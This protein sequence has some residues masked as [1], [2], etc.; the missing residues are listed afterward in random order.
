M[1]K[2]IPKI[3]L[4]VLLSLAIYLISKSLLISL[5]ASGIVSVIIAV[6]AERKKEHGITLIQRLYLL[7][8][9]LTGSF[10]VI[11]SASYII[12]DY[13]QR[14]AEFF[15]MAFAELILIVIFVLLQIGYIVLHNI[16]KKQT[17]GN[18]GSRTNSLSVY[19]CF[20]VICIYKYAMCVM[21]FHPLQIA[22]DMYLNQPILYRI[23]LYLVFDILI[24]TVAAFIMYKIS[25]FFCRPDKSLFCGLMIPMV[26]IDSS[27]Y[28]ILYMLYFLC[29]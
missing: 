8:Y 16:D 20:A 21:L 25:S 19:I 5:T 17:K 15:D 27:F 4:V 3:I 1:K 24:G 7:T 12:F 6:V 23:S 18:E 29:K 9:C 14:C 28:V 10:A 13:F 11:N 26:L 22:E 2:Q